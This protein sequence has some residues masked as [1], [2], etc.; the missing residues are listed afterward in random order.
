VAD[1]SPA[2]V[3]PDVAN[4]QTPRSQDRV[5]SV[6]ERVVS[7]EEQPLALPNP[8]AAG[9]SPRVVFPSPVQPNVNA[10]PP[11]PQPSGSEP[12]RVRTVTI[13]ADGTA[14]N[15]PSMSADAP[16]PS[17]EVRA[18]ATARASQ[19]PPQVQ[20][21]PPPT[22][23]PRVTPRNQPLSLDPNAA[24]AAPPQD[25][26]PGTAQRP[27][28]PPAPRVASAPADGGATGGYVVQVSSQRSEADARASFRALQAK[29][30]Q[31]LNGRQPLIKRADLGPKGVYYRAMVGPFPSSSDAS[32]F[33]NSLK[34]AGGQCL[35]Q[36]N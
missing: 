16:P 6:N 31:V 1:P 25:E 5:G 24:A 33:C 11:A 21:T 29:Y 18:P 13:R 17:P 30:P 10:A 2:K 36:R 7:R 35:I 8:P 4:T 19:P 27:L 3:V 22:Q 28:T 15:D 9:G 20:R 14:V 26:P 12:K 23:Q 34:A 32:Q